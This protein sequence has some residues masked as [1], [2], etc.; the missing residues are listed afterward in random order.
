MDK[1]SEVVKDIK[2]TFSL[3]S[4]FFHF[5]VD[6]RPFSKIFNVHC[7][8]LLSKSILARTLNSQGYEFANISKN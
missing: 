2:A 7:I 6:H 3:F 4:I 5:I 8:L 1:V